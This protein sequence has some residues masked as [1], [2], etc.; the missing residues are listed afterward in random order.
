MYICLYNDEFIHLIIIIDYVITKVS[1]LV[2]IQNML[3]LT[4]NIF[5]H[6]N[7]IVKRTGKIVELTA[8]TNADIVLFQE[9][10]DTILNFLLTS[11]QDKGYSLS[12]PNEQCERIIDNKYGTLTF[13]KS[14]ITDVEVNVLPFIQT[15][16][17]R[18]ILA[19]TVNGIT[20]YNVHLESM[21]ISE[22]I[23]EQQLLMILILVRDNPALCAGDFNLRYRI[24]EET[25]HELPTSDT[26]Y[27]Y[28]FNSGYNYSAPYD[29]V[30]HN[31]GL[32]CE[33]IRYIGHEIDEEL[34]GYCSDHNG[35]LFWYDT[36]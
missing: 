17:G 8:Q 9:V 33:L 32:K 2:G 13:V 19:I 36:I 3:V 1:N 18:D 10:R 6:P 23:R 5:F 7:N 30:I 20:L 34:E 21:K 11:M 27:S 14:T 31:K 29:R 28:R 16:M 24:T 22:E 4:W 26:Y 35:I 15:R 12:C 25:I